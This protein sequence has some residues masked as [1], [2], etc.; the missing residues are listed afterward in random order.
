MRSFVS[1]CA[2]ALLSA[3]TWTSLDV[4][5]DRRADRAPAAWPASRDPVPGEVGTAPAPAPAEKQPADPAL[6]PPPRPHVAP[7]PPLELLDAPSPPPA[8]AGEPPAAAAPVDDGAQ[9]DPVWPPPAEGPSTRWI[10]AAGAG[11]ELPVDASDPGALAWTVAVQVDPWQRLGFEIG[12]VGATSSQRTSS[13]FDVLA[14]VTPFP[15]VVQPYAFAG[16]GWRS[17]HEAMAADVATFPHGAGIVARRGRWRWDA[18][19]VLRPATDQAARTWSAL[20][21]LGMEL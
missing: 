11:A 9:P 17:T 12:Y 8:P 1:F 5:T 15:G 6:R 14:R 20:A 16:V 10:V 4:A 13:T 2:G 7:L 18:R 21:R 19:L 3:I